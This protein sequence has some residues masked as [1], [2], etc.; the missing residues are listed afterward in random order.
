M[1]HASTRC[2]VGGCLGHQSSWQ[3]IVAMITAEVIVTVASECG[4]ESLL[5]VDTTYYAFVEHRAFISHL[6]AEAIRQVVSKDACK[7]REQP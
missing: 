4:S 7:Y 2:K 1:V 6:V 3:L 5:G